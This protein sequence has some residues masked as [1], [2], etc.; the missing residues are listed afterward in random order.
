MTRLPDPRDRPWLTVA[1]LA[2]IT[3]VGEKA[4]RAAA[5]AGQIPSVKISR[6]LRF[7]TARFM[8]EV[9]GIDPDGNGPGPSPGP[10]AATI[11]DSAAAT[12]TGV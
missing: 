12:A 5:A 7:P 6:Y 4:I 8:R 10:G 2:E 1:E 11:A 3:G 9:L